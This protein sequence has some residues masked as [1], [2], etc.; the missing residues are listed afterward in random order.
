M[1]AQ[2]F[3]TALQTKY[4]KM[5]NVLVLIHIGIQCTHVIH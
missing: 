3:D 5:L 4:G 1:L 2:T